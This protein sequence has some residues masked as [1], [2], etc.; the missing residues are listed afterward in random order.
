M[1]RSAAALWPATLFLLVAAVLGGVETGARFPHVAVGL[2]LVAV[3]ALAGARELRDPLRLGTG[4]RWLLGALVVT[5]VASW[6][7]SQMPRAGLVGLLVLPS[8]LLLPAATARL[9]A[10]PRERRLGVAAW[11][12]ALTLVAVWALIV[13]GGRV[14]EPVGDPRL[15]AAILVTGLPLAALGWRE[16][17]AMRWI[18][19]AAALSTVGVLLAT[20]SVVA[21]LALA[22]ACAVAA[23]RIGRGRNLVARRGAA[24]RRLDRP[25]PRS[26]DP[27]RDIGGSRAVDGGPRRLERRARAP[28]ARLGTG[29]GRLDGGRLS[30]SGAGSPRTAPG[31]GSPRSTPLVLALELGLPA[32]ALLLAASVAFVRARRARRATAMDPGLALAGAAGL[33]AGCVALGADAWLTTPASS[34]TLALAAG[35]L[36][37]GEGPPPGRARRGS[38]GLAVAHLAVL[39][40][41]GMPLV[42]AGQLYEQARD[43]EN[44]GRRARLLTDAVERDPR[45]PLYRARVA[46]GGAARADQAAWRPLLEAA[47][48]AR[49]VAPL[50]LRAAERAARAGKRGDAR[51]AAGRALALAPHSAPAA[52]LLHVLTP[53]DVDC[54][55]R[56]MLVEPRLAAA[57][58]W[59]GHE[60]ER[61]RALARVGAWPGVDR[62]WK[63]QF[64]RQA[65]GAAPGGGAELEL[66]TR[67][68]EDAATSLSLRVFR[69][70]PW[71]AEVLSWSVDRE[72]ASRIRVPPATTRADSSAAAF[73]STG[74]APG[75]EGD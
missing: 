3:S 74:C 11:G 37:A 1:W 73:P 67:L 23:P 6:W 48:E 8:L 4:A 55:A 27:R 2:G 16:P 71:P 13:D 46:W 68:D 58:R 7:A 38:I 14:G 15:L 9:L 21:T 60:T 61:R 42:A 66:V 51:R 53:G 36:F 34:V 75:A 30:P 62:R 35:F 47:Y 45:F 64:L 39:V 18:A 19:G 29:H 10:G 65:R 20:R 32:L 54:A 40:W 59:R 31:L 26:G 56:A 44:A 69:R 33:A 70:A 41:L 52:F 24:R 50:W 63:L 5:A 28:L 17:G 12:A 43:E 22:V 72:A 49:G 57:V 25:R